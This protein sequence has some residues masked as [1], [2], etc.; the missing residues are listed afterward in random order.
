MKR[1]IFAALAVFAVVALPAL[2]AP[3]PLGSWQG[4]GQH[5]GWIEQQQITSTT[6]ANP[7]GGS[8]KWSVNDHEDWQTFGYLD[9]GAAV[10][11]ERCVVT[12]YGAKMG[13][14]APYGM[15]TVEL[16][17]KSPDLIVEMCFSQG[18]C[19]V[20]SPVYSDSLYH[21]TFCGKVEYE[22]GDPAI[23][24]IPDSEGG[25]GE[26]STVTTT[27]SNPT[28]KRVRDVVAFVGY[29]SDIA[30]FMGWTDA[31]G[32]LETIPYVDHFEYPYR[33]TQS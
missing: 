4:G 18:R 19:F 24:E 17:A 8:C 12:D 21:W 22:W 13:G 5:S 14:I 10:T 20:P 33:W 16:V 15:S 25:Y 31:H 7:F 30:L 27:I 2:A 6:P 11:F 3:N 1:V 9:P 28:N 23:V 26:V 29:A 32:C